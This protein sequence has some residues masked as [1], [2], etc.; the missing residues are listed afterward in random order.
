MNYNLRS[1]FSCFKSE[2]KLAGCEIVKASTLSLIASGALKP[3]SKIVI[4]CIIEVVNEVKH[5]TANP[6]AVTSI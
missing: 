6:T 2:K 4:L 1:V 5:M 3:R